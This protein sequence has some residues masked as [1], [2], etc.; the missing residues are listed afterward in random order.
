MR[1]I[2]RYGLRFDTHV[3]DEWNTARNKCRV[4]SGNIK[5]R[6]KICFLEDAIRTSGYRCYIS[7]YSYKE[8]FYLGPDKVIEKLLEHAIDN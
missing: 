5:G 6:F 8:I 7:W 2:F 4:Y 1:I 3:I